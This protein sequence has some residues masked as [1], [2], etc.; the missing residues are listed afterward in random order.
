MLIAMT[1]LVILFAITVTFYPYV[2]KS[3]EMN[4]IDTELRNELSSA[5]DIMS[6]YL[7]RANT[8]SIANQGRICF[9]ANTDATTPLSEPGTF[10][11]YN[12][13]DA[14]WPNNYP[15]ASYELKY[16]AQP[17]FGSGRTLAYGLVPMATPPKPPTQ[18]LLNGNTIAITLNAVK[19]N[20]REFILQFEV[21]PRNM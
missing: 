4:R 6:S 17:V 10:Y 7:M 5:R 12:P 14:T 21:R 15:Y 18:F 20:N 13:A 19:N 9:T 3:W 11:L 16:T 2:T 8:F 1:L